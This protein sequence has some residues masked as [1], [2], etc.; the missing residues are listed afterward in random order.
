MLSLRSRFVLMLATLATTL[1]PLA[2]W[3]DLTP[4]PAPSVPEPTSWLLFGIGGL[5]MAWALR[6]RQRR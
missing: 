1:L 5:G 4:Q 6:R 3:A 2:A